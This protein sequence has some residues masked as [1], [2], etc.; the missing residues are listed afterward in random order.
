MT[1]LLY[2]IGS[3][4][5]ACAFYSGCWKYFKAALSLHVT[6]SRQISGHCHFKTG[7]F[8]TQP[9]AGHF[10]LT[11][12]PVQCALSTCFALVLPQLSLSKLFRG[13]LCD[14]N[15][16]GGSYIVF[17]GVLY[18][19]SCG[20]RSLSLPLLS[21]LLFHS[22]YVIGLLKKCRNVLLAF[23]VM[24]FYFSLNPSDFLCRWK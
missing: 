16:R 19:L 1:H 18:P 3:F 17:V 23:F 15:S 24:A 2:R 13:Y 10:T 22:M 20:G 12:K 4:Q 6:S 14:S 7:R 11:T 9:H 5:S 8:L 21:L